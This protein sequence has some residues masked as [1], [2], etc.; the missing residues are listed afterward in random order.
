[1]S[2]RKPNPAIAPK[3]TRPGESIAKTGSR[4]VT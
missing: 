2:E 4:N 3:I 1:M